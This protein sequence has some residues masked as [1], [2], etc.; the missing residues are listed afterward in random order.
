M[1]VQTVTPDAGPIIP[2]SNA[3]RWQPFSSESQDTYTVIR[4]LLEYDALSKESGATVIVFTAK[5]T[6]NVVASWFKLHN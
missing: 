6:A 3:S 1:F 2:K 5:A 4:I